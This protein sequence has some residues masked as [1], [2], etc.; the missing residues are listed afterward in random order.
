MGSGTVIKRAIAKYGVDN[1]DKTILRECE[2]E[3][4][5]YD[6]EAEIVTSEFIE[7]TDTYNLIH[8]GK[9]GIIDGNLPEFRQKALNTLFQN[10]TM[11][12]LIAHGKYTH[13]LVIK[14]YGINAMRR[15][16]SNGGK[17]RFLGKHHTDET[18]QQIGKAN[19]IHQ[20]G[21]NNSQYGTM[22]ITNGT[23]NK[24]IKKSEYDEWF[25]NGWGKGRVMK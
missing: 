2:S 6:N 15:W 18:K 5:M 11:E 9:N 17:I 14:K 3:S 16:Q 8:G 19:S 24:K 12:E 22:W 13:N 23:D 10:Y 25:N 20:Q 7:R 21:I 4:D 1:F